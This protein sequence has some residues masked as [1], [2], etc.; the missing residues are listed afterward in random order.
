MNFLTSKYLFAKIV[1]ALFFVSTFVC[2]AQKHDFNVISIPENLKTNAN[3]VIR[4]ENT[5]I[6]VRSQKELVVKVEKAI[7]IYNDLADSYANILVNYDK[8]RSIENI[9]AFIYDENGEEIKKIK[10]KDFKDYSSSDGMSLYNDGRLLYYKH[11]ALSYPYTVYYSYEIKTSNTA[12]IPSWSQNSSY[13][14]SIQKSN[15]SFKYPVDFKLLKSEYNFENF[16]GD[17]TEE[18]GVLGLNI[19]NIEALKKEPYTPVLRSFLP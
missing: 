15:F 19:N 11:T 13:Y 9:S 7:T 4:F 3:S 17:K 12:F 6:E 14:Q 16:K 10:K 8:R 5:N 1:L 18:L 2:T